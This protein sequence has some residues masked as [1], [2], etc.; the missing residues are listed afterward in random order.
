MPE[1]PPLMASG[2][3]EPK[4]PRPLPARVRDLIGFMVRGAPDDADG[5]P[6]DFIAAAK[7][8][9]LKP[10]IARR[11]LDRGDFRTAL[12]AER[13]A[14]REAICAGNELALARI[15]G[16]ENAMAAVRSI[17]LLE[18][19]DEGESTR[20][21]SVPRVP[22]MVIQIINGPMPQVHARTIDHASVS[23]PIEAEPEQQLAYRVP[24]RT[25]PDMAPAPF[26]PA[27]D[28]RDD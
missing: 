19:L 2:S 27:I 14:F 20:S 24:Y 15:R 6:L 13:A 26:D 17:Q 7:L 4:K 28:G 23:L 8:A 22:G 25:P 1:N 10:D 9:N 3:R 18:R 12:R 16:G 21:G 11:W 5:K